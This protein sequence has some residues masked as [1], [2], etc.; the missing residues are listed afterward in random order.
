MR[1]GLHDGRTAAPRV[2]GPAGRSL[3]A[4][5]NQLAVQRPHPTPTSRQL[6]VGLALALCVRDAPPR[7]TPRGPGHMRTLRGHGP[8]QQD[9]LVSQLA[10]FCALVRAWCREHDSLSQA[11]P[12]RAIA[13]DKISDDDVVAADP[14][15][16]PHV[17]S[18]RGLPCRANSMLQAATTSTALLPAHRPYASRPWSALALAIII[19]AVLHPTQQIMV[20]T[21]TTPLTTE[22]QAG[23]A[24]RACSIVP[25]TLSRRQQQDRDAPPRGAPACPPP[26]ATDP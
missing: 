2:K 6:S 9:A 3:S 20:Q 23:G 26:L 19:I 11:R 21:P 17:Y 8:L 24:A 18:A 12:R 15:M 1:T 22:E 14:S 4:L 13:R 16:L 5:K 10:A 7:A 25:C